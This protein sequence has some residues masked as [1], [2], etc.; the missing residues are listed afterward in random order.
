[1][2]KAA[3]R[4]ARA[5]D[6]DKLDLVLWGSTGFTGRLTAKHLAQTYGLNG[7]QLRWTI[8]GRDAEK[9]E[10]L[11]QE[12][13]AT[14]NQ[15]VPLIADASR[16][17][18]LRKMVAGAKVVCTTV[19]PFNRH[20]SKLVRACAEAGVDYC[21]VTG[22]VLWMRRMMDAYGDMAA[23]SGARIVHGCGFD[24]IPSDLGVLY[25]QEAMKAAHDEYAEEVKGAA[26]AFKGGFSGGTLASMMDTLVEVGRDPDLRR[27]L[28]D[29]YALN[30]SDASPGFDGPDEMAAW[31]DADFKAWAAPFIMA[32]VNTRVVRRSH[33]LRGNPYGVGFR[34]TEA[35]LFPNQPEAAAMGMAVGAS[36]MSAGAEAALAVRPLLGASLMSAGALAGLALRPL[37]D[38]AGRYLPESGA[39]AAAAVRPLVG[40]SLMSVGS[41]AAIAARPLRELAGRYLPK[42][43]EGPTEQRMLDGYFKMAFMAKHASDESKTI[44]VHVT[45]DRDPG[46]GATS[47][48]LGEAAACLATDDLSVGGGFHTPASALGNNLIERLQENAGM[49]FAVAEGTDEED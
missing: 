23:K 1:M 12:L 35:S 36:L 45:G 18:S 39:E 11:R 10:A 19:G 25:A 8:A 31:Y 24:S 41:L 15:L 21:D 27:I 46:Y 4:S 20:G 14:G 32:P 9:L 28:A 38:L 40:A 29:P 17:D 13:G 48:M 47:R 30:P 22:E 34:Y 33:A 16:I 2:A 26:V 3:T 6:D 43:G 44:T 49:V 42:P 7:K 5:A 37:R